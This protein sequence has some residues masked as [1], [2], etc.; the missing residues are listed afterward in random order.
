[1]REF[2]RRDSDALLRLGGEEF[3]VLMP[4][5]SMEQARKLAEEFREDLANRG[6]LLGDQHLPITASLGLGCFAEGDGGSAETFF[7]RV[8]D[9]LY[10]AKAK[11]RDRLE[12]AQG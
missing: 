2:F 8:D 7:K 3:G 1:M 11:G 10:R 6:F 5:T 9:A 12:L 4:D